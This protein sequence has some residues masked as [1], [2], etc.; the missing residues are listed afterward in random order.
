M[1]DE[2][3]NSK[4]R[5]EENNKFEKNKILK[6]KKKNRVCTLLEKH[7]NRRILRDFFC[8]WKINFFPYICKCS[9]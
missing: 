3:K 6:K 9:I 7:R 2:L 8:I 4:Q 1:N 5:M